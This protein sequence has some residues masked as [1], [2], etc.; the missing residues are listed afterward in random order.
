MTK[1]EIVVAKKTINTEEEMIET[2]GK[3]QEKSLV[4]LLLTHDDEFR[5]SFREAYIKVFGFGKESHDKGD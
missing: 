4:G 2:F 3:P 1:A 5:T